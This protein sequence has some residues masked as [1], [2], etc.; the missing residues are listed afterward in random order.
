MTDPEALR[1]KLSEAG[2][3]RIFERRIVPQLLSA[4]KP[5][6]EPVAV[7]LVGQPG[8]GK[9]RVSHLLA[10]RLNERGGFAD[11]DSDLYKPYHPEYARLLAED[12]RLMALYTGPDG[13]EWMR[14]AQQYVRE[15]RINA[16]VQEIADRGEEFMAAQMRAYREAGF[17][18]EVVALAVSEPLSL[19]GILNRYHEQV[20]ER[21]SGRLTVPE[22]AAASYVGI[23]R[24]AAMIDAEA[25]ADYVAVYRRGEAEP[26]YSNSRGTDGQWRRP[27]QFRQA[28][29]TERARP[30]TPVETRD[31]LTVQAKLYREMS[32][33]FRP[34]I[35]RI[36]T[37]ARSL[38]DATASRPTHQVDEQAAEATR[39]ARLA[40]P[41]SA[42]QALHDPPATTSQQ[43]P[44]DREARPEIER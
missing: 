12:D 44:T 36:D 33:D 32:A 21:G 39:L 23:V 1:Y 5:Q 9:T 34:Q 2:S 3:R 18:V 35:Q 22:K 15:N 38:L 29:E 26:R 4:A 16:L 19:Q 17:R 37:L 43:P 31:F 30:W 41:G 24:T 28:I 40:F 14:Q 6:Q 20:K 11:I 42:E 7:F 27:P 8:A 13:R 10:E 25:A